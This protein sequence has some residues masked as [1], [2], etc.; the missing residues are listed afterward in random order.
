M[1]ALLRLYPGAWRTRYGGEMEA[2][3]E[4][5][6][7]DRRER[8]DLIRGALDAW[9]HPPTPSLAPVLAALIGGGLWTVV[10]TAVLVQPAPPDWPGY[11]A[12]IVPLAVIAAVCLLV[13]A[14]ACS[15]RAGE[16]KGRSIGL[17]TGLVIVGHLA[18]IA[19]LGATILGV[20][21]GPALAAAQTLAMVGTITVG[22]ILVRA[23]D[24]P[25]GYLLIAAP[26]AMLVPW[27]VTWLAFGAAW[28]AIGIVM[29]L[30]R[31]AR[32]GSSRMTA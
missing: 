7:P 15:L 1:S 17:A 23:R 32:T 13:A 25:I 2:L 19:M 5:R 21:G 8:L 20:V 28:T 4:E 12:E 27:T 9:L 14:T 30:D 29:W 3:L 22:L 6:R 26:V 18:W 11:L 10:A 24:E 31:A 16:A